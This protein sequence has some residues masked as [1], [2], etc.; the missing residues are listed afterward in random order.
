MKMKTRQ[1]QVLAYLQANRG[2]HSPAE[3]GRKAWR[4][5]YHSAIASSV[6]SRMVRV[7]LLK[8][9]EQGHYCAVE[10]V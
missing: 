9:N 4:R 10:D 2:Y 1:L 5:D 7:G 6:C 3:I 8:R